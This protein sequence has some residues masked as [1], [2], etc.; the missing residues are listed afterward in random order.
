M[1]DNLFLNFNDMKGKTGLFIVLSVLSAAAVSVLMTVFL[2]GDS[3]AAT[4]GR[5]KETKT[6][7][8]GHVLVKLW[9]EY[10][11]ARSDDRPLKEAGILD[12]II[13]KSVS[14]RLP[15]DFYDA[16][17]K[18]FHSVVSRNWKLGDESLARIS[19]DAAGF[20]NPVVDYNL[21]LSGLQDVEID[22]KWLETNVLD[23]AA[24]LKQSCCRS[25]YANDRILSSSDRYARFITDLISNDYEYLL[26][27]LSRQSG[28][29]GEDDGVREAAEKTL[30]DYLEMR[31]SARLT[32]W[33]FSCS[34]GM[35]FWRVLPAGMRAGQSP[36]MPLNR[37]LLTGNGFLMRD[38]P[39]MPAS[40]CRNLRITGNWEMTA[41]PS[42]VCS[43]RAGERRSG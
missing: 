29:Y 22:R 41:M 31:M 3:D 16:S 32:A 36:C 37:C 7:R 43:G 18:W 4:I 33:R 39:D 11:D 38:A 1:S 12:E 19:A 42:S 34:A 35:L 40:M 2:S 9:D 25:F 5:K 30:K 20:G 13:R 23:N 28:R 21:A 24:S 14:G 15:W 10:N 17:C 8:E 27:S 26:W 6:D